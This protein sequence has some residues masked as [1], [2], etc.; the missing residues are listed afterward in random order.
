MIV[1]NKW[2]AIEKDDKTMRDWEE[3]IRTEC[4]LRYAPIVF[5]S[6][7]TKKRL[8]TLFER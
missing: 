8:H 2:D 7:L 4:H 6:A 3:L 5:L 1:V